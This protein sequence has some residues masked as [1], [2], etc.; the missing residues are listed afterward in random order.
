[1][2]IAPVPAIYDEMKDH[3]ASKATPEEILTFTASEEAEAR[4]DDL[5][6]KNNAGTLTPEG[7]NE[8]DQLLYF[9]GRISVRSSLN[10]TAMGTTP[11]TLFSSYSDEYQN[12]DD[13]QR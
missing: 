9:D 4:A 1:M 13:D 6:D 11:D 12:T 7:R 3:L 10:L 5:L 8:R 2:A